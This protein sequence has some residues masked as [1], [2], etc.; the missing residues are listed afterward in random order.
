LSTTPV[1]TSPPP[2]T[3]QTTATT[4]NPA[5]GPF[6]SFLDPS[7]IAPSTY[8]ASQQRPSG[9]MG[10]LGKGAMIIDKFLEGMSK[11]RAMQYAKSRQKEADIYNRIGQTEEYVRK[12]DIDPALQK[13]QIDKLE[14]LRLGILRDQ[15]SPDAAGGGGD[16]GQGG[17]KKGKKD[18]QDQSPIVKFFHQA[19][20]NMLGPGAQASSFDEKTVR[21]TLGDVSHDVRMAQSQTAQI[22]QFGSIAINKISKGLSDGTIKSRADIFKD[23]EL[24]QIMNALGKTP[25]DKLP[26]G[27]VEIIKSIP[28]KAETAKVTDYGTA[29]VDGKQ[30]NVVRTDKGLEDGKGN[31]V[32]LDTI[33]PGSLR[34]GN[35]SAPKPPT[36]KQVELDRAYASWSKTL[37]K[38]KLDDG[39][40][41]I[42]ADL[43]RTPNSP[44]SI[45]IQANLLKQKGS[46]N[47][48][49]AKNQ[50]ILLTSQERQTSIAE[51]AANASLRIALER[52]NLDDKKNKYNPRELDDVSRSIINDVHGDGTPGQA[53]ALEDLRKSASDPKDPKRTESAGA[54]RKMALENVRDH[55]EFYQHLTDQQRE[56]VI[57]HIDGM[58][59]DKIVGRGGSAAAAPAIQGLH[60]NN[61]GAKPGQDSGRKTDDVPQ[62]V[63]KVKS[64]AGAVLPKGQI[65]VQAPDGS[66]G[67]I[68]ADKKDDFAKKHPG[69]VF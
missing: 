45:E 35:E 28:E 48:E 36:E 63:S 61:T 2:D 14:A 69:S 21:A 49:L 5:A 27:L 4:A 68:P 29:E 33:K 47:L 34:M 51:K 23:P 18:D 13:Q 54:L 15:T 20:T 38:D 6:S 26:S 39:E 22:A 17:K 60:G 30:I 43:E 24:A 50:A 11:G 3:A 65:W 67:Y 66:V 19:A 9:Y 52:M 1:V 16:S 58:P 53:K 42:V 25:T 7:Q 62:T 46:K 40:K 41:S 12:S 44:L 56:Q 37:G 59:V 32:S 64:P 10:K 55:P 31:P 57:H 8:Q